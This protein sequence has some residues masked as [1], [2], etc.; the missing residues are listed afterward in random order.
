MTT[1]QFT[2]QF[3]EQF[4]E[5][6]EKDIVMLR[7]ENKEIETKVIA[8]RQKQ[9][10]AQDDEEKIDH[11]AEIRFYGEWIASNNRQIDSNNR[12]I[13]SNNRQIVLMNRQLNSMSRKIEVII[14]KQCKITVPPPIC[15][16]FRQIIY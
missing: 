1:K 15:Y 10:A 2:K 3:I 4:I 12:Q 5:R 11:T 14:E 7:N 8:L 9:Q 13:D 6:C 16:I